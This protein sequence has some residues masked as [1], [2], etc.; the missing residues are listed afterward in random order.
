MKQLLAQREAAHAAAVRELEGRHAAERGEQARRAQAE[1][2]AQAARH[3]TE[4]RQLQEDIYQQ[5]DNAEIIK[6]QAERESEAVLV[7]LRADHE[8]A[9]AGKEQELASTNR[10]WIDKHCELENL[11]AINRRKY[12]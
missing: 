6:R 12:E 9:M 2:E 1:R 4:M 3:A 5:L 11:M 10:R 7:R 8:R